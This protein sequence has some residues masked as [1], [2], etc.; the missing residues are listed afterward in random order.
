MKPYSVLLL[1]R[2]QNEYPNGYY[3]FVVASSPRNAESRAIVAAALSH[4]PKGLDWE[5]RREERAEFRPI[6]TIEGHHIDL[7]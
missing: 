5:F 7:S 4:W 1:H 2:D 6:L 3:A